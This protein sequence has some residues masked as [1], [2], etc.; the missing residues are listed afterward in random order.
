M[1]PPK[2]RGSYV[3]QPHIM[4]DDNS[5]RRELIA[6]G[7]TPGPITDSTR[8]VLKKKLQK[9]RRESAKT[10]N[11]NDDHRGSWQ[12]EE[13]RR[14]WVHGPR[15]DD[16]EAEESLENYK[17]GWHSGGHVRT[18]LGRD[19]RAFTHEG[20]ERGAETRQGLGSYVEDSISPRGAVSDTFSWHRGTDVREGS[21]GRR[22]YGFGNAPY[23]SLGD[24][25][26]AQS[27]KL[28]DGNNY[29]FDRCVN[30]G[31]LRRP[32]LYE[33]DESVQNWLPVQRDVTYQRS[34][35]PRRKESIGFWGRW[36]KNWTRSLVYY[37]SRVLWG[38]SLLLFTVFM[39]ILIAKSGILSAQQEANLKLLPSD[40]EG[41]ENQFCQAKQKKITFEILSELYDFL[42]LEAGKFECGNPDG[43][44]SKCVPIDTAREH[45]ANISG[46]SREKFDSAL[47]WMVNNE[48]HLGIWVRGKDGE[49]TVTASDLAFC[50]ESSRPR[51][52]FTCRF[53]N[54]FETALSNLFLAILVVLLLWLL[55]GILQYHWRRLEET[56]KQMFDMVEKIIGVV[57]GHYKE[58][59]LGRE[60][61]PYVGIVH[62]RDTLIPP[63]DRKLLK[64]VW[65]R[66]VKFV[67]D[68]ESRLRTESQRVAGEDLRVWRWTQ[69]QS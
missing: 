34:S 25:S 54:A 16:Y 58:W 24:M 50:V 30:R 21:L 48:K 22:S 17:S 64:N 67:E 53:K 47:N 6:L 28:T 61:T 32:R 59:L 29:Q 55:F 38:L 62:V 65:D 68:N 31:Q 10:R 7:F 60:S 46:H 49:E 63:R 1:A 33:E 41:R 3:K 23:S 44:S 2:Q 45:V 20:Q 4:S 14:S 27:M 15:V 66:A 8:E 39:W 40:C 12:R 26:S 13:D 56:E 37:F 19:S 36:K 57:K 52:G 42:S 51:L 18:S 5:L 43:L 9:L 11:S 69:K 35:V